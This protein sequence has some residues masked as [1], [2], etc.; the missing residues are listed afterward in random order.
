MA[1]PAGEM[2]DAVA[3]AAVLPAILRA[4]RP[5]LAS[6]G[7]H[8]GLPSAHY[9]QQ[10]KAL[11]SPP[12]RPPAQPGQHP[13]AAQRPE[14]SLALLA[15]VT[16]Y[17]AATGGSRPPQRAAAVPPPAWQHDRVPQQLSSPPPPAAAA[18]TASWP[19]SS[20]HAL[21]TSAVRVSAIRSLPCT[22]ALTA[23][24]QMVLAPD[25]PFLPHL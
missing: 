23:A 22:Q 24:Q 18:H 16:A 5:D 12:A 4:L 7:Q 25:H 2:N 11:R 15:D 1:P 8:P 14:A 9:T 21:A 6:N 13:T 19:G 3:V 20:A 10:P 17:L